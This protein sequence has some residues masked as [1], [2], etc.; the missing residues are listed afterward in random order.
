MLHLRAH[1]ACHCMLNV[2]IMK[3]SPMAI[4]NRSLRMLYFMALT[5]GFM[6]A[7][8]INSPDIAHL[9]GRQ[10]VILN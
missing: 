6:L 4:D 5:G 1:V 10:R 7:V 2:F 8:V 3:E 9:H